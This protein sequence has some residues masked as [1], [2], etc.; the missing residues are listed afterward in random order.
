M[1]EGERGEVL[2]GGLPAAKADGRWVTWVVVGAQHA[3][4]VARQ[5]R[6]DW[7]E[8]V[9]LGATAMLLGHCSGP[10][11]Q[12]GGPDGTHGRRPLPLTSALITCSTLPFFCCACSWSLAHSTSTMLWSMAYLITWGGV[13]TRTRM[14]TNHSV[15][16]ARPVAYQYVYHICI[17]GRIT[18]CLRH[19]HQNRHCTSGGAC[20]R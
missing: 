11:T 16:C 3:V 18:R 13:D 7:R 19:I 12:G 2:P 15:T 8:A 1:G 14:C 10:G 4:K 9:R 17:A 20:S 5:V 6:A